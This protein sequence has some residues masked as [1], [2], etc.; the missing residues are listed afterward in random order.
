MAISFESAIVRIRAAN[1]AVAGA[2]FLVDEQH[3]LSCAHVVVSALGL[4]GDA[5][6]LPNAD[7]HLDFPLLAPEQSLTARV[8][9]WKPAADVAVLKLTGKPPSESNPVRLVTARDLWEHSFRAYGFPAG[10]DQGVWVSG[11]L[12][13]QRA[14]GWL[15]MEDVK[16]TG[17]LIAPGF[18]GGA[19]WDDKLDGVVGMVVAA[20]VNP[21]VRAAY[22]IPTSVLAETLPKRLRLNVSSAAIEGHARVF[23]AY[24]RHADRD[25][26]LAV[27]LHETLTGQRHE[28]FIDQTMRTGDAWLEEIDRQIKASDFMIVLLS[29]ES[30][31]SE[32]VRAEVRRAYEYHKLQGH[33]HTLPVRIAY[34]GLLPYAIDAFLNPLQYVVWQS[35]ADDERVARE[36]LAA[37]GGRLPKQ[38]PVAIQAVTGE[39]IV[40][41]DGRPVGGD[42][43]V[44]HSPLP[45][46]DPRFLK[47]LV[48]PGGAVRLSDRLY[49]ERDAD[50]RLKKEIVKWGTTTTI[51]ASRQT[52]K[53]S[54]LMRG[55]RHAH[56]RG[57]N[58]AFLDFQSFGSDQRTSLDDFLRELA[59]SICDELDL[60][61]GAVE[62]AWSGSRSALKKMTRF[63][64]KHVLPAFDEPLVLAMDEADCLLQT[65]FY[66][67]FF[68]LLRSWH[69]RRAHPSRREFWRKLNLVLVISTEPYLLIADPNQSPFNV[70]L[71]L[72][73]KDFT[74]TQVRNLNRQHG[75]PVTESDLPQLM[76]LLS[77]HP[78]LTRRAFYALVTERWTWADL[79][80]VAATDEGPFGDH[81][82]CQYWLLRDKPDLRK[83]LKEIIRRECCA[84]EMAFFRL[85]RAGL[86]K[87]SGDVCVCRCDLYKMYFES[88]L[89]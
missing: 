54:L 67:D 40:S 20:D 61:Q 65:D 88:K 19:V 42:E 72:Y 81:L 6:G 43:K 34:E 22:L 1:G 14:G 82:R 12:R 63:M 18:S 75:S 27:Y 44:L 35:S 46:F 51:R 53:T 89:R 13:A 69:N 23:I 41:E 86:V 52:G 4:P 58:V 15:Q 84:D 50:A 70:G 77:G 56:E 2:G 78:Y 73:L 57:V 32:M 29:E 33:P 28:V 47:D 85:L 31:N 48:V 49:V 64:E 25:Q 80:R 26:K 55:I 21:K 36:I 8:V 71:R 10:Y 30:A 38:K 87:G 9:H 59:E 11:V 16:E 17:Y 83:A 37:I 24:K 79:T 74:K 45:E 39:T 66:K 5:G 7:L 76:A 60:D 3:I 62:R 68:G